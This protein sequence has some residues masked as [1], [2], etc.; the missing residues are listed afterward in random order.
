[1]WVVWAVRGRLGGRTAT[2]HHQRAAAKRGGTASRVPEDLRGVHGEVREARG[3]PGVMLGEGGGW[4]LGRG[5]PGAGEGSAG[6]GTNGRRQRGGWRGRPRGWGCMH[7][8]C[9]R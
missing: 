2:G 3:I 6:C 7:G 4:F 9:T 1:M 5:G 8:L